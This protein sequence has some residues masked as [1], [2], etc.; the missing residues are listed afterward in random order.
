MGIVPRPISVAGGRPVDDDEGG[1][2]EEHGTGPRSTGRESTGRAGRVWAHDVTADP[3]DARGAVEYDLASH[4][5]GADR[6]AWHPF[7]DGWTFAKAGVAPAAVE[8]PHDAMISETRRPDAPSG[9]NGAYFPGGRYV[10]RKRWTTSGVEPDERVLLRFE[11]ISRVSTV[12][13]NGTRLG[14]SSNAYREL[15][16][17]V[18][19]ALRL[20]D[21][22]EIEVVADTSEQPSGRWYLGSGLHRPISLQV[23]GPITLGTNGVRI[24]T[25]SIGSPATVDVD[26]TFANAQRDG[27]RIDVGITDGEGEVAHAHATTDGTSSKLTLAV[28]RPSL[29]SAEEPHLYDCRVVLRRGDQ[30]VD[31]QDHRIGLRIIT[32]DAHH[33]LR[34]N[35]DPVLL[36]GANIHHDNGII[37]SIAL[38]A[39]EVR[40]ATLLKQNGFNAIRSAHN[41]LSRAMIDACDEVGLYVIDETTDVWWNPKTAF[42]DSG[43]FMDDWHADLEALV[44]R[45]R[46]RAS[47]IMLSISNENSETTSRAGMELARSMRD[48]VHELDGTRPVTAGVNLTLNALGKKDAEPPAE[49][50]DVPSPMSST[51]FNVFM[52]FAGPVMKAVAV[53]PAADHATRGIF[54][55][56][57]VAGYN[58]G[59]NRWR[60]DAK[61][62]P[63]RIVLGTEEKP[64][65]IATVWALVETLPNVIGDFVWA[66]WDYLGETGIGHWTY[67]TRFSWL[68][69]AYPHLTSGSGS[70]DITGVP[71]AGALLSQAAW[72]TEQRPQIAVRPLDVSGKSVAKAAWRASDAITSWSWQGREGERAHV[73]VYS[74]SEEVDLLLNG[75]KIGTRKAGAEHGFLARFQVPYRP[76]ELVAIGRSAGSRPLEGRLRSAR[77]TLRLV[78]RVDRTALTAD[79]G[80]LAYVSIEIADADGIV[81]SLADDLVTVSIDGP[82]TLAGYGSGAPATEESFADDRHRTY[83][84]RALAVLRATRDPGVVTLTATSRRHG[85]ASTEIRFS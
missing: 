38:P 15:E 50:M 29:W 27:V 80:D 68:M 5:D 70:L 58:Y 72:G 48:L 14:G 28:S 55:V 13:V 16:I 23:R 30:I 6:Y 67:G 17:D 71:G 32:V 24:R 82:A 65:D 52:H 74:C 60:M 21:E 77:G 54:D 8:V 25:T 22:N 7:T 76:G 35:D 46:N 47:V 12:T 69:K 66:G 42:D 36:R 81:E 73:E 10:Y 2:H 44:L 57:D 84:G 56:L 11:G 83:Y 49:G 43:R 62:H 85:S 75:E 78:L 9:Y 59:A 79:G 37:G 1:A 34:V 51:A 53:T 19:D 4:G 63:T 61:A 40:R 20:G 41:P 3:F 33:G 31:V 64:G 45:D 39:A 18:T 26:V